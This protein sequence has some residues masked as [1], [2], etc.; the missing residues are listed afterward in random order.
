MNKITNIEVQKKNKKRVNV[1]VDEEF[2]FACDAELVYRYK[3]SK[4][5]V[6]DLERIRAIVNEDNLIKCKNSALRVIEKAYKT[7]R[8]IVSKLTEKGYEPKVIE[9]TLIF[10]KEYNFLDDRKYVDLYINDKAKTQGRNKILY[11]LIRKGIDENIIKQR[12]ASIDMEDEKL[13]AIKLCEKK[14]IQISKKEENKYILG[15]KLIRFIVSKGYNYE[16]ANEV[17]KEVLNLNSTME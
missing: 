16:L 1:Y 5:K 4:G 17:V 10:L 15:Q 11:T 14:Y 2:S 6:I 9:E 13:A 7:E 8:E 12:L 3:L